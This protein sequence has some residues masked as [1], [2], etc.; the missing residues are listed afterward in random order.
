MWVCM[1]CSHFLNVIFLYN[2]QSNK[3]VVLYVSSEFKSKL[4]RELSTI[5]VI[6]NGMFIFKY[7]LTNTEKIFNGTVK[8]QESLNSFLFPSLTKT[9]RVSPDPLQHAAPYSISKVVVLLWL[10][11][12][13]DHPAGAA[14]VRAGPAR[15]P[16]YTQLFELHYSVLHGQENFSRKERERK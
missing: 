4:T 9:V 16:P 8:E 11:V 10:T 2:L 5:Y 6:K 12:V 15:G 3:S 1:V 7:F 13:R 14:W